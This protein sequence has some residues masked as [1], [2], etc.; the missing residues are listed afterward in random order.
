MRDAGFANDATLLPGMPCRIAQSFEASTV[1]L[2][3]IA[4]QGLQADLVV[5]VDV[6]LRRD[7]DKIEMSTAVPAVFRES[8]WRA[9]WPTLPFPVCRG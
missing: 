4:E 2:G 6:L 3:E 9:Q 7:R 5:H 1:R 8:D